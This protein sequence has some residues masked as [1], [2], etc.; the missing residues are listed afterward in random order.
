M[1]RLDRRRRHRVARHE[2]GGS[3]ETDRLTDHRVLRPEA[4]VRHGE[5]GQGLH[6]Q[7]RTAVGGDGDRIGH[8]GNRDGRGV[9]SRRRHR[10]GLAGLDGDIQR[11]VDA[12]GEAAHIVNLRRAGGA[13]LHIGQIA[14]AGAA[15][16]HRSRHVEARIAH[17]LFLDVLKHRQI[18]KRLLGIA[19]A[20]G[21]GAGRGVGVSRVSHG[22]LQRKKKPRPQ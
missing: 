11:H 7:G 1:N 19:A 22:E 12:G 4:L 10:A 18:V 3:A 15:D 9:E 13:L 20:V 6:I 16:V 17:I 21:I 14:E 5:I 2:G 8:L